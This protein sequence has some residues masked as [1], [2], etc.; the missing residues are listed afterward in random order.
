MQIFNKHFKDKTLSE[1]YDELY[2]RADEIMRKY[3]PCRFSNGKC[4]GGENCCRDCQH[5][6]STGCTAKA[7]ACKLWLCDSIEGLYP[8]CGRKLR[9]VKRLAIH[10]DFVDFADEIGYRESKQEVMER[11]SNAGTATA[12]RAFIRASSRLLGEFLCTFSE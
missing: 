12:S 3:N 2:D 5:M 10:F 8:E 4:A 1:I 11:L 7:L 6:A 9:D